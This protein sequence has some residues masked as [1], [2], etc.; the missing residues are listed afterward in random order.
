MLIFPFSLTQSLVTPLMLISAKTGLLLIVI[1]LSLHLY[2]FLSKKLKGF[3]W[4]TILFLIGFKIFFQLIAI[5]PVDIWP[6]EHGVRIL[7][8]HLLLLGIVSITIFKSFQK[9]LQTIPIQFFT[10]S[11]LLV[12]ASLV[13][14]SG[15]AP[16]WMLPSK[17]Y[18]WVM[19]V[20][21]LP[22]IPTT[23]I[24]IK[25]LKTEPQKTNS[26]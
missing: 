21:F 16:L 19:Y 13:L 25:S 9:K 11:V 22:V 4:K 17:P 1:S 6:G 15:Y 3:V 5:L 24:L 26:N 23:W 18:Q 20:A 2:L 12:L 7:Y 10:G 14:I 8:L